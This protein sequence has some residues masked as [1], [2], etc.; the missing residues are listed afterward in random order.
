M[1]TLQKTILY[2][3]AIDNEDNDFVSLLGTELDENNKSW[4]L[5][6]SSGKIDDLQFSPILKSYL[7]QYIDNSMINNESLYDSMIFLCDSGYVITSDYDRFSLKL[8]K[9]GILYFNNSELCRDL[10]NKIGFI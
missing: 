10:K 2:Y 3:I 6:G 7:Y 1:N 5:I 4:K 8:T 9:K